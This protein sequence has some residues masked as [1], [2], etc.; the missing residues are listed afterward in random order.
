MRNISVVTETEGNT[1]NVRLLSS[2]T[3]KLLFSYKFTVYPN[4]DK[5]GLID[6][7]IFMYKELLKR[8]K[9][10]IELQ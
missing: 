4:F 7:A 6:D 10:D 1:F 9:L 8:K 5:K 3:F 2:Q